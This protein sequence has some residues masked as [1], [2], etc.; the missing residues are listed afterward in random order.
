MPLLKGSFDPPPKGCH[1]QVENHCFMCS[2]ASEGLMGC[3]VCAAQQSGGLVPRAH[4]FFLS[5][6]RQ[7]VPGWHVSVDQ[8]CVLRKQC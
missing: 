2:L 7:Q 6:A 3:P 8:F 1:P 5:H 4:L